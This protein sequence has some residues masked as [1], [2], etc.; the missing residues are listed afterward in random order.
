MSKPDILVYPIGN[1]LYLNLT[2]RCTASCRFCRRKTSP[3]VS[4]Y[5]LRLARE[6]TAAEY[7]AAMDDPLQYAE[8]VFCGYG[9]P[10][11]RLRELLEI[12]SNLKARGA[13]LRLNTNGH[14]NLI[15][16]RNIVP[17]LA[18]FLDE[19]SI[20]LNA[21]DALSYEKLVCPDFGILTFDSVL[22]F[23]RSCIG[24]IPSVVLTAVTVPELDLE[25]CRELARQLKVTLHFRE[26]Q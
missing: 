7:L 16:G 4:G 2:N 20:S 18:P 6:H 9:E 21:P 10:T 19:I 17:D 13:R 5:D 24:N 25:A 1:S 12:G 22:R 23:V 3:I 14:G 11:L 15:H 26:Y 8:T